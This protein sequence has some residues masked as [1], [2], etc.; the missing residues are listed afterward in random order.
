MKKF[1]N[2]RKQTFL[3]SIP[4]ASL[5][6]DQNNISYRMKFNFSYFD[7]SQASGLNLSQLSGD[8][9]N[10]LFKKLI[11]FS[12]ESLAH[13]GNIKIGSGKH[14]NSVYVNY[15]DFPKN[16]KFKHPKF[17]PHQANWGRFRLESDMRLVGFVVP[18]E[19]HDLINEKTKLRYDKNTFYIVFIDPSHGFYLTKEK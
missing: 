18:N 7:S 10:K 11:E 9:G 3:D 17:V 2:K 14:R 8:S 5:D 19:Y 13:W 15:G 6:Q 1:D 4:T 12:R 16:S